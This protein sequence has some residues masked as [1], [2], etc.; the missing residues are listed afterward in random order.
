MNAATVIINP[1]E[2]SIAKEARTPQFTGGSAGKDTIEVIERIISIGRVVK[3]II[4][5]VP[6]RSQVEII[7]GSGIGMSRPIQDDLGDRISLKLKVA[8]G[9]RSIVPFPECINLVTGNLLMAVVLI[10]NFDIRGSPG[11]PGH[12]QRPGP[13]MLK[14]SDPVGCTELELA[15]D[16]RASD[17]DAAGIQANFS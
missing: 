10:A 14:P 2:R 13:I 15:V 5:I 8:V 1:P 6:E 7:S 16:I 4:V 3:A 12:D 11:F 9:N 17:P